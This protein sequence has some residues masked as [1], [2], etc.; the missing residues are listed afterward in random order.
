VRFI[1]DNSVGSFLSEI[2]RLCCQFA[3]HNASV[4][5]DS[6]S[7]EEMRMGCHVI[8]KFLSLPSEI[9]GESSELAIPN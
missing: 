1:V 3:F 7:D 6:V 9:V 4:K 8:V 5:L 2:L